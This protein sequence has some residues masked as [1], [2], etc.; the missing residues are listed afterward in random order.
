KALSLDHP[1]LCVTGDPDQ[2]I[3]GWRGANLNNILEFEHDYPGCRVVKLERNYRSTK[4]ILRAADALI[5]HNRRRKPKALTT[6]NPSG[7]PVALTVYPTEADEARGVAARVVE[8][9]RDGEYA[10][11]DVAVFCRVTALTRNLELAFRAAK[12]PY[13]VVGGVSF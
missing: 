2:S 7:L 1:N 9:V 10:Y 4:N 12:V 3:Y 8:K 6:E 11:G 13:Q 5:R